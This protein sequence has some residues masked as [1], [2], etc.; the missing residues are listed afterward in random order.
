MFPYNLSFTLSMLAFLQENSG[1]GEHLDEK[2]GVLTCLME[3]LNI[4]YSLF[5]LW[6]FDSLLY[7]VTFVVLHLSVTLTA[8][9]KSCPKI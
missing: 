6:C 3:I 1:P 5:S 7:S 4:I 8:E 9:V 2:T